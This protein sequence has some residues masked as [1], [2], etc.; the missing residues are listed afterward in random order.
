MDNDLVA[1][2][3][4]LEL[5]AFFGGYPLI[6][7]IVHF[8]AGE[9]RKEP[10]A[11][12]NRLVMLLPFAYAF[13]GTLFLALALKNMFPDFSMKNIA[14]QFQ[15]PYIK[16]W[17]LL[18]VLFWIPAFSKKAVFS[19]LHSLIFFF[20]LLKDLFIYMTASTGREVIKND[21]KIYTGSLLLNTG[22]LAFIVIIHFLVSSIRNNKKASAN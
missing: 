11:F 8:I 6:Y 20:F 1:Y 17:G 3:E 22:T 9:Q 15:T 2:I 10:A 7:A 19:L 14:E 21:M 18:A 16:I 12:L 5:I 13:T 4:R